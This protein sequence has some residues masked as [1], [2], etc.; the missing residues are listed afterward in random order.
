MHFKD[1]QLHPKIK[2]ISESLWKGRLRR[3][4][5]LGSSSG[6][7]NAKD[8]LREGSFSLSS[9]P[10]ATDSTGALACKGIPGTGDS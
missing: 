8:D 2:G 4:I 9:V 3:D 1:Q 7:A 6:F 5:K 10:G